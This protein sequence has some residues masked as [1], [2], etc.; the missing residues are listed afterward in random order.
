MFVAER[1][2]NKEE[3]L[4]VIEDEKWI[5]AVISGSVSISNDSED[6][7]LRGKKGRITDVVIPNSDPCV[8]AF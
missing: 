3:L 6:E 7:H 4:E 1:S 2:L 5:D 8:F